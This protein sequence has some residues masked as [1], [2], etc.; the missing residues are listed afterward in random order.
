MQTRLLIIEDEPEMLMFLKRF[1]KRKGYAVTGVASAEE[2]WGA[3]SETEYDLVL[4][5]LVLEGMSG[6]E[7]LKKS[8]RLI[9]ICRLSFS[10]VPGPSRV[11]WRRS[12]LARFTM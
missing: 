2:A 3:L 10:R 8:G 4:S 5:D 12:S 11:P 7:L 9:V 1:Y 6:M